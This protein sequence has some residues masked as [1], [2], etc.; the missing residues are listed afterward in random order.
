[1]GFFTGKKLFILGFVFVLLAVI[2]LTVYILQQQQETRSHAAPATSLSF[3]P[4]SKTVNVGESFTLD[5]ML[6][7]GSN[8]VVSATIHITYD[9]NKLSTTSS[10]LQIEPVKVG[11]QGLNVIV[12]GPDYTPG[13]IVVTLSVGTDITKAVETKTKIATLSLQPLSNAASSTTQVSFGNQTVVT[14]FDL[15]DNVWLRDPSPAKII[16][17]T[18][19]TDSTPTPTPTSQQTQGKI[20]VCV[21]LNT[22][23]ITTGSVPF[24]L[25]FTAIGNDTDGTISKA[26]FDFGD[27]PAQDVN[28]AGGFGTSSVNTQISH[29]YRNP[30]TFVAKAIFT[31]NNNLTSNPNDCN[32]TITATG[33]SGTTIIPTATPVALS[34]PTPSTTIARITPI[35]SPGPGGKVLGVAATGAILSIIGA[36]LFFAL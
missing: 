12:S 1:M 9:Q 30:G 18:N 2:P 8:R 24:D 19:R 20:P 22:D 32:K 23:R 5:V 34:S 16:I 3:S 25:T 15:A 7:P 21:S 28:Q 36:I 4:N 13:N 26:T 27:G 14:A 11:Q 31:D 6:D 10:G 29:T 35:T 17:T 33:S